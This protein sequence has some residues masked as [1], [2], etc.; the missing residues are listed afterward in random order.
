M[1]EEKAKTKRKREEKQQK[2]LESWSSRAMSSQVKSSR[3]KPSQ[4]KT[5]ECGE[6]FLKP[7]LDMKN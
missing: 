6:R 3:A 7:F 1:N 5:N 4:A 2:V